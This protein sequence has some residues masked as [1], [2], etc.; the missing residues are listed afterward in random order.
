MYLHLNRVWSIYYAWCV[1]CKMSKCQMP[2][3]AYSQ[4]LVVPH[5]SFSRQKQQVLV[6][7]GLL[8]ETWGVDFLF[9]GVHPQVKQYGYL[10]II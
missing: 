1:G 5:L 3:L 7:P 8:K 10:F 6:D 4:V 2:V 9:F